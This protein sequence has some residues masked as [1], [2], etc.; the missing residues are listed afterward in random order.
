LTETLKNLKLLALSWSS[1]SPIMHCKLGLCIYMRPDL[2]L[3]IIGDGVWVRMKCLWDQLA[4][5]F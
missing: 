5:R 2:R 4:P 1:S 3:K